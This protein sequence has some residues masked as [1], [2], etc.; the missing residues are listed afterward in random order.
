LREKHGIAHRRIY[1]DVANLNWLRAQCVDATVLVGDLIARCQQERPLHY[2]IEL[3]DDRSI[4]RRLVYP[5]TRGR[6]MDEAYPAPHREPPEPEMDPL[7]PPTRE[8][9]G[10]LV[11]SRMHD[12]EDLVELINRLISQASAYHAK[13]ALSQ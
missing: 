5:E 11:A 12:S 10:N 4:L 9:P 8:L 1:Y 6:V 2:F 13:R 7:A 3:R